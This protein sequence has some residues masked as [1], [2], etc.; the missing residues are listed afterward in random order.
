MS[1]LKFPKPFA[2]DH[3]PVENVN[4][5]MREQLSVGQRTADFVARTVG[6]WTFI[7]VQSALLAVWIALNVVAYIRHWDPYPFILLNLALSFQAAYTA[8]IIMM[9]QNRQFMRDRLEAHHDYQVN[10]KTEIEVRAVLDHLAAQDV[11]LREIYEI[12]EKKL[13]S[14]DEHPG[15]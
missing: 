11:A 5:L 13:A 10:Q 7:I 8:P 3:P 9:S 2:H 4:E 15:T 12:L 1:A 6:S 14:R